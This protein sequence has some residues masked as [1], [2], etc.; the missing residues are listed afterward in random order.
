MAYLDGELSPERSAAAAAHLIECDEC[1]NLVS[2]FRGVSQV[3]KTWN[4][5]SADAQIPPA[6]EAELAN[7]SGKGRA[8][9][10]RL[11]MGEARRRWWPTLAWAGG[12]AVVAVVAIFSTI[13]LPGGNASNVFLAEQHKRIVSESAPSA[14]SDHPVSPYFRTPAVTA[15]IQRPTLSVAGK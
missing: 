1:R 2:S 3:M 12:L 13:R 4:V 6:V 15:G 10:R 9:H 7:P 14:S 11:G 5:E 8:S